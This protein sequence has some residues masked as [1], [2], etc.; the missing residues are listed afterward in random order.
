MFFLVFESFGNKRFPF[1]NCSSASMRLHKSSLSPFPPF[2]RVFWIPLLCFSFL[3]LFQNL[4][5][6]AFFSTWICQRITN[7]IPKLCFFGNLIFFLSKI[8]WVTDCVFVFLFQCQV[9]WVL[10]KKKRLLNPHASNTNHF[11]RS[12]MLREE[13]TRSLMIW[14]IFMFA[15]IWKEVILLVQIGWGRFYLETT[16]ATVHKDNVQL[17]EQVPQKPRATL[18][19]GYCR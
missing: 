10:H 9:F 5:K 13:K 12:S 15:I 19:D 8:L 14:F 7:P 11:P 1:M 3:A 6:S 17:R 4:K 18:S 16:Q 2:L